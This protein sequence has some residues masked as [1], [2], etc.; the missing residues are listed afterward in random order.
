MSRSVS[1]AVRAGLYAQSSGYALPVLLEITHGVSGYTNPLRIVNNAVNLSYSGN[2]YIAFPFKFDPPD[3][4]DSGEIS[5]ARLSICAIDQQIASIVRSTQTPPTV[6]AVAMFWN[7]ESGTVFE[8]MA[9]WDFTMRNI[10]GG[11][12]VISADLI[13]ENRLD[14]EF[15]LYEFRPTIVPGVH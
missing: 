7:D 12:D 8:P 11:V 5:H 4:K 1:A 14:L 15:P 13:Y 10:S 2:D 9:S 6:R 3:V